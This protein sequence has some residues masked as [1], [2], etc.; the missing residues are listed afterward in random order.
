MKI[1]ILNILLIEN[2]PEYIVAAQKYIKKIKDI[3]I[4]VKNST[5]FSEGLTLLETTRFDALLIC[6][7]AV[8]NK[9]L[10]DIK[11][12]RKKLPYTPIVILTKKQNNLLKNELFKIGIHVTLLKNKN[13]IEDAIAMLTQYAGAIN[14]MR[15]GLKNREKQLN[16]IEENRNDFIRMVNHEL[17]APIAAISGAAEIFQEEIAGPLNRKYQNFA[18]MIQERAGQL[19]RTSNDLNILVNLESGKFNIKPENINIAEKIKEICSLLNKQAH[20]KGI[21]LKCD[22]NNSKDIFFKVNPVCIE[23]IVVNLAQN[24]FCLAKSI[25]NIEIKPGRTN[26]RIIVENDGADFAPNDISKIFNKFYRVDHLKKC[27]IG[28][29]IGLAIAKGITKELRGSI[30]AENSKVNSANTTGPRFVVTLPLV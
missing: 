27:H 14:Y 22:T 16:R 20:A 1:K 10:I 8:N 5:D 15:K 23:H 2:G 30:K 17:N 3:Q 25:V 18:N 11:R 6:L 29:S 13:A 9:T 4:E 21:K 7:S 28:S 19:L 26:C 24:S 12:L